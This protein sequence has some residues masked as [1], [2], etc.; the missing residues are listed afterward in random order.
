MSDEL[1][2]YI[3]QQKQCTKW[4]YE[5][6]EQGLSE[7]MSQVDD[8]KS[9]TKG[10][11]FSALK[12][13]SMNPGFG[14]KYLIEF[15]KKRGLKYS[16]GKMKSGS[17]V[18]V[19]DAKTGETICE[20]VVHTIELISLKVIVPDPIEILD[21]EYGFA[22]EL[23]PN[24]VTFDRMMEGLSKVETMA[25]EE[26]L[27]Q[28]LL[29]KTLQ[30]SDYSETVTHTQSKRLNESQQKAVEL[31]CDGSPLTILH[32]PPGT[33]KTSTLLFIIGTYV[34]AGKSVLVA[35]GTNAAVDHVALGLGKMGVP[36]VR[37]GNPERF[38]PELKEFTL[39]NMASKAPSG[40][41]VLS[42]KNE[43]DIEVRK[44]NNRMRKRKFIRS[45]EHRGD[46]DLIKS[47]RTEIK[48]LEGLCIGEL[49][50]MG[51]VFISTHTGA[52]HPSLKNLAFDLVVGEEAGQ[53]L[54]P[55]MYLSMLKSKRYVFAGDHFQLPPVVTSDKAKSAGFEESLMEKLARLYPERVNMLQVQYRMHAQI[56]GF[57]S[58]YFYQNKLVCGPNISERKS[59]L[60]FKKLGI[61][62]RV[63]FIDTKNLHYYEKK[64]GETG[65]LNNF[66][67]AQILTEC[68]DRLLD[69]GIESDHI[70]VIAPYRGQVKAL[71]KL[72][73][74]EVE[75]STVDSYQGREK[76]IILISLTRSN[77]ER[78]IGFLSEIRR[79][80]VAITRA[81]QF[82]WVVGDSETIS[83]DPFFKEFIEY[84]KSIPGA[85]AIH[86]E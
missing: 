67:E 4:E 2:S 6:E 46:L 78:I 27:P 17:V 37:V 61:D 7:E 30:P 66:K 38:H 80:N 35:A 63:V 42:F 76:E 12:I 55:L 81:K 83:V 20:G 19:C 60:A 65:G 10:L 52:G 9:E 22:I 57:S 71:K 72:L 58:K 45:D 86:N 74:E 41:K 16:F 79:M 56:Q 77:T 40:Q 85:Y 84:V 26:V 14:G 62:S 68:C 51:Y 28:I 53:T 24:R 36:F 44:K 15:F 5:A 8:W 82:L 31:A 50:E 39:E 13:H 64:T 32:G 70:G 75:V 54:E 34:Q 18:K 47:Y 48:R 1:I 3:T 21:D 49:H 69:A 43:L 29:G 23:R 33:G 25:E 11:R 73:P 59:P